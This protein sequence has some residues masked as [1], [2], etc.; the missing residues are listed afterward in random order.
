MNSYPQ[1]WRWRDWIFRSLNADKGYDRMIQEMLAAD[2]LA[3]NDDANLVATG[4]LAR[5]WFKWNYNQWQRDL[6]EHTGKAF[7]GITLNCCHCHDHKYDPFTQ[8]DYFSFRA[9]F[10]PLELRHDRVPGEPDPGPF[11]KYVYAESYGPIQSGMVRVFDENLDALTYVYA[12]GDERN[13]IAD[14]PPVQ[15]APPAALGG[16]MVIEPV[17]LPVTA[18]YPGMKPFVR[19]EELTRRRQELAAAEAGPSSGDL[20]AAARLRAAQSE[21]AAL[22]SCIAADNKRFGPDLAGTSDLTLKAGR[23]QQQAALDTALFALATARKGAAPKKVAE[24]EKAVTVA[25][26]AVA[27]SSPSYAPL[28]PVYPKTSTG[29][30]LALARWIT[31]RANP[32]TARVAA[33]HFWA[34]HFGG[35]LVAT[36]FD[37]GRNGKAPSNPALL[38]WLAVELMDS[39]WRMKALHRLLVTSNSYRLRSSGSSSEL[40]NR[41]LAASPVRR[42]DAEQVRDSVLQLGGLLDTRLGGKEIPFEQGLSATR[43]SIYFAQ[44]GEGSMQ[45]LE[46]FDG[47]NPCDGYK[48]TTSILPH[49]ALAMVNNGLLLNASR[50]LGCEGAALGEPEFIRQAF[51]LILGR[52][53]SSAETSA[54]QNFLTQQ[55]ELLTSSSLPSPVARA[56]G[57]LYLALFN[58]NDFVT[59]R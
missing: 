4:F 31:D 43:R 41:L 56:R 27:A 33:N 11:K 50:I 15:P 24:A 14:R 12:G 47:V 37:F 34:R 2:E 18:W 21:L 29:R 40:Q 20:A 22:E 8:Q 38:D 26:T 17:Y 19:Q 7:L 3:P 42:M 51:L 55:V 53:P 9:C 6:V 48:R 32:L 54:A 58:H 10:E 46:L 28:G 36:T 1:I 44:H 49:Q 35:P 25:R 59:I 23:A 16:R 30:R 13:R 39:G 52:M 57:N 45:F 5:N